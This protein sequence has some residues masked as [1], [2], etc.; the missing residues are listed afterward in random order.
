[1]INLKDKII[2]T[3]LGLLLFSAGTDELSGQD[4]PT[5]N[6]IREIKTT[7]LFPIGQSRIDPEFG[8][9][10]LNL[11][12]FTGQ[13]QQILADT[14]YVVTNLTITG[15]ASPDGKEAVNILL[16]GHRAEA[17]A[18]YVK[19]RVPLPDSIIRI[20]NKGENWE[21]LTALVEATPD[22][23]DREHVLYVLK[24]EP[25]RDRRKNKL[26]FY[27]DSK[28]WYYMME[29][30]FS[31]LR[32][33]GGSGGVDTGAY[34]EMVFSYSLNPAEQKPVPERKNL[35]AG[36][37]PG[38]PV[39]DTPTTEPVK[40]KFFRPIL[41]IKTDLLPWGGL[42]PGFEITTFMPNLS[43]E[44]YFARR[45]SIELNA[46]YANWDYFSGKKLW[47]VTAY[48]A[49]PRFWFGRKNSFQGFHAGLYGKWGSFDNQ[50][51][52]AA[53]SDNRTGTFWATGITLGF[54]QP[55]SKNWG[56]EFEAS[57]GYYFRDYEYYDIELPFHYYSRNVTDGA[58]SG[59]IR[60][61]LV[62]RFGEWTTAGKHE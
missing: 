41:A 58:F 51:D 32:S 22:V 38:K 57:G 60:V 42:A 40:K 28:A 10:G 5:E 53:G 17:M 16:A 62:Y 3:T 34:S 19:S 44:V 1:M 27:N 25:D 4:I 31:G 56:L 47:A 48:T 50:P 24:N 2:R 49:E 30:F 21:A 15:A 14:N 33:V 29:H 61:K 45:W 37:L 59:T 43:A 11:L 12:R 13:L 6:S 39:T 18:E 9:N 7:V 35:S 26:M 55:L 46:L 52:K 36:I 8:Y 20:R 23:P 54:L